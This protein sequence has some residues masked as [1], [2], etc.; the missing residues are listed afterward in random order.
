MH[1]GSLRLAF[2]AEAALHLDDFIAETK[3]MREGL[4][5]GKSVLP[6]A[7]CTTTRRRTSRYA[8]TPPTRASAWATC[9]TAS[10]VPASRRRTASWSFAADVEL[11]DIRT[12]TTRL[13]TVAKSFMD[14]I[15]REASVPA[16]P[17]D[18]AEGSDAALDKLDDIIEQWT[19][20]PIVAKCMIVLKATTFDNDIFRMHPYDPKLVAVDGI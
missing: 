15:I 10:A 16:T 13:F 5:C 19:G 7:S 20:V 9:G 11:A 12:G 14:P 1:A 17:E 8:S 18:V 4:Q 3:A 6:Y 2:A